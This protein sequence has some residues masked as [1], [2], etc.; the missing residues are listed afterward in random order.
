MKLL[1]SKKAIICFFSA[2]TIVLAATV[3]D[4]HS[5]SVKLENSEAIEKEIIPVERGVASEVASRVAQLYFPLNPKNL[6]RINAAWEIT[7]IVGNDQRVGFDKFANPEDAKKM[8]KVPMELIGNSTV[9]V[10]KDNGQIYRISLLSDFGTIALFK[11]L[12]NGYEIIEARKVV[13]TKK[14]M[15]L[16]VGEEVELVLERALNQAKSNKVLLGHEVS[17][18]VSLSA[19]ALNGLSVELRN[20]N[21]EIQNI[22]IDTADLMDGGTF[23]ADISGEEVSGVV[24]NNGKDGYRISFVTGPIAG[25]M[26]NFVT[27]DQMERVEESQQDA[28]AENTAPDSAIEEVKIGTEEVAEQRREVA[29]D[30]DNYQPI[31]VLSAEEVKETAEQKGFSF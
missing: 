16:V 19:R 7:R 12:G 26:L 13:T 2:G 22:Q 27:K 11:K 31:K 14:N 5:R 23:K 1:I 15:S 29:S 21:G 17:G 30:A 8:I 9:R 25:S 18:Q 20:P 10:N 4:F 3:K 28:L 6:K 24:F